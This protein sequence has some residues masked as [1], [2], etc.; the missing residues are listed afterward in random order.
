LNPDEL[1]WQQLLG[2]PPASPTADNA[3]SSPLQGDAPDGKAPSL[4]RAIAEAKH[5]LAESLGIA[6][7]KIEITI[8]L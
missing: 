2:N 1:T 8:R 7:E 4:T 6:S 5:K 3:T